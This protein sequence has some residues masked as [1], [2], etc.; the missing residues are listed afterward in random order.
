MDTLSSAGTV[1]S[2]RHLGVHLILRNP[3]IVQVLRFGSKSAHSI[4]ISRSQN[5]N[6]ASSADACADKKY[7]ESDLCIPIQFVSRLRTRAF[8]DL[9]RSKM[10][11][12]NRIST[13]E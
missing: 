13:E 6:T 11:A 12:D 8:D 10:I 4:T 1:S 2:R 5:M 9:N 3:S 7:L